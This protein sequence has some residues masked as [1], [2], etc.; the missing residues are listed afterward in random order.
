MSEQYARR[1]SVGRAGGPGASLSGML[2]SRAALSAFLTASSGASLARL[3]DRYFFLTF[4][5][6][7]LAIVL[8]GL[9]PCLLCAGAKL[10]VS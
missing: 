8:R 3:I 1:A 10:Q 2:P 6:I 4:D 9:V 5:R 7:D